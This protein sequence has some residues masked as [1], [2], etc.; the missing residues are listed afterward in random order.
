MREG[1]INEAVMRAAPQL[2]QEPA[3]TQTD[4]KKSMLTTFLSEIMELQALHLDVEV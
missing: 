3:E 4:R 2:E 1:S